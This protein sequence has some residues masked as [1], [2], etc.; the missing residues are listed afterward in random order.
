M[1]RND[2]S[3]KQ[4]NGPA[5]QNGNE[6]DGL[7]PQRPAVNCSTIHLGKITRQGRSD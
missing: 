4:N 3:G 2:S 6:R 5:K 1:T 7:G